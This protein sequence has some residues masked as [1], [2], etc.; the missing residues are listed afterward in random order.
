MDHLGWLHTIY[1]APKPLQLG[2][3]AKTIYFQ[4][5]KP[6]EYLFEK[7]ESIR[8]KLC[9]F[10]HFAITLLEAEEMNII[11][12]NN[13]PPFLEFLWFRLLLIDYFCQ[14]N[15]F[16]YSSENR[17]K[18]SLP[19]PYWYWFVYVSD[20]WTHRNK[21]ACS[22][23]NDLWYFSSD[24]SISFY[25]LYISFTLTVICNLVR[26]STC[27]GAPSPSNAKLRPMKGTNR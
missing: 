11:W 1:P 6:F 16:M 4:N 14:T 18:R 26:N 5:N 7:R 27:I 8:D 10:V 20:T 12:H 9:R 17:S 24:T 21:N 25:R 19:V 3:W 15:H 13:C 22:L 2:L 23:E